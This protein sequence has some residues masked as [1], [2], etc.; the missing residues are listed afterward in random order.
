MKWL[1]VMGSI[2]PVLV[3]VYSLEDVDNNIYLGLQSTS[4]AIGDCVCQCF[5]LESAQVRILLSRML[6]VR[7]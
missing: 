7:T 4:K 5:R 2:W 3:I 1:I 6:V